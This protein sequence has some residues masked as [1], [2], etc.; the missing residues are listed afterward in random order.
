MKRLTA[1]V[2]GSADGQ[3]SLINQNKFQQSHPVP[4]G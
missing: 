4:S 1:I 3:D 2:S